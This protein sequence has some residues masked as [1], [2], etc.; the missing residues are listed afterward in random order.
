VTYQEHSPDVEVPPVS[1]PTKTD[2]G[3]NIVGVEEFLQVRAGHWK[4][5]LLLA[6]MAVAVVVKGTPQRRLNDRSLQVNTHES[7]RIDQTSRRAQ[8][9]D[10]DKR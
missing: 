9:R 3:E 4:V 10:F 6:A 5:E 8:E 2:C 1:E 7:C